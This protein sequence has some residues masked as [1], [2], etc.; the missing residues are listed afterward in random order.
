MN[1]YLFDR[2]VMSLLQP[3]TRRT[4]CMSFICYAGWLTPPNVGL[5]T[6][7]WSSSS[8]VTCRNPDKHLK[9]MCNLWLK[10]GLESLTFKFPFYPVNVFHSVSRRLSSNRTHCPENKR[11]Q[12]NGQ[13]PACCRPGWGC[14][15]R[16][17]SKCLMVLILAKCWYQSRSALIRF[18]PR[19][20]IFRL[21]ECQVLRIVLIVLIDPQ[22]QHKW[23]GIQNNKILMNVHHG[24]TLFKVILRVKH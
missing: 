13:L 17:H 15:G 19:S 7:D 12:R 22:L 1:N 11:I 24:N 2:E 9:T 8:T 10:P 16:C 18:L 3:L 4:G 21:S 23:T 6:Y 5:I 20:V 14:R